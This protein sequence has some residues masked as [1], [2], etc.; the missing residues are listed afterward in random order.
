MHESTVRAKENSGRATRHKWDAATLKQ[1]IRS[2]IAGALRIISIESQRKETSA[3]CDWLSPN[4][5]D[6]PMPHASLPSA[7][8]AVET[9]TMR[10][11]ELT[12][13]FGGEQTDKS[14][15][16]ARLRPNPLSPECTRAAC[17][18]ERHTETRRRR[19]RPAD[20]RHRGASRNTQPQ[21]LPHQRLPHH[22]L[23]H[24]YVWALNRPDTL[25]TSTPKRTNCP[26]TSLMSDSAERHFNMSP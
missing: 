26:A 4:T 6:P 19:T 9:P 10:A 5:Q 14:P 20:L 24:P 2:L 12:T 22:R 17:R 3:R 13:P 1:R 11:L 16:V 15:R 8:Q 25:V 7:P 23:T 18:A 21:R